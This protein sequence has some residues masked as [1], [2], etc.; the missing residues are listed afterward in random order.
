EYDDIFQQN[1]RQWKYEK[2]VE[3]DD[4]VLIKLSDHV[5][6]SRSYLFKVKIDPT[7]SEYHFTN[8]NDIIDDDKTLLTLNTLTDSSL[9]Y[10]NKLLNM[11]KDL[12]KSTDDLF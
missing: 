8:K 12:V 1:R 2:Q 3:N 11:P 6:N 4:Y 7:V 9:G 5:K 10:A